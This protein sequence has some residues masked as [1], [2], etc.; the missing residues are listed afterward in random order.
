MENSN[1]EMLFAS[2]SEEMQE[3]VKACRTA[4]ELQTLVNA[5]PAEFGVFAK[6]QEDIVELSGDELEGVV[7]GR[8]GFA[9]LALAALMTFTAMGATMA[10][11]SGKNAMTSY[12]QK[13]DVQNTN[14]PDAEDMNRNDI[15]ED[16]AVN[17]IQTKY[18][19]AGDYSVSFSGSDLVFAK[20]AKNAAANVL[21]AIDPDF[22]LAMV[23]KDDIKVQYAVKT[24]AADESAEPVYEK[25]EL[26]VTAFSANGDKFSVSFTDPDAA[27]NK[28]GSYILYIE[29]LGAVAMVSVKFEDHTLSCDTER[30]S[31]TSES[32]TITLTTAEGSFSEEISA[33][34]IQ[35][36]GSF[37][38]MRVDSVRADGSQLHITLSGSPVLD[39]EDCST[40]MAGIIT[41]NENGFVNGDAPCS[42]Y[43][44][45]EAPGAFV[46]V[47]GMGWEN[48]QFVVPIRLSG[49]LAEDIS[50]EDVKLE[51]TIVREVKAAPDNI[52][53]AYLDM[54][55]PAGSSCREA[56]DFLSGKNMTVG[57]VETVCNI[58]HASFYPFFDYI[59][60]NGSE[61]R[62]TLKLRADGGTIADSMDESMISLSGDFKDGRIESFTV[63]DDTQ[64]TIILSLPSNGMTEE[65]YSLTGGIIFAEGALTDPWGE[66]APEAMY[67]RL[68][69]P[70]EM[71]RID[72]DT[73]F[74]Y[75]ISAM[76][77]IDKDAESVAK[78][79]KKTYDIA[80]KMVDIYGKLK[81]FDV[82]GTC[83]NVK[84]LLAMTGIITIEKEKSDTEIIKE[85]IAKMND[86]LKDINAKLDKTQKGIYDT[87]LTLFDRNVDGMASYAKGIQSQIDY[88]MQHLDDLGLTYP[89]NDAEEAELAQFKNELIH[90][91]IAKER[92]GGVKNAAYMGF[93]SDLDHMKDY[94]I[95]TVNQMKETTYDSS[96]LYY[97]DDVWTLYFNWNTEGHYAR[98]AYR[99][100]IEFQLKNA[101]NLMTVCYGLDTNPKLHPEI[102]EGYVAALKHLE[103]HPETLSAANALGNSMISTSQ[104][105]VYSYT[106]KQKVYWALG[107]CYMPYA[108]WKE[109]PSEITDDMINDYKSRL[110]GKTVK[111]DFEFA[112]FSASGEG[113]AMR[114][115]SDKGGGDFT[116]DVITRFLAGDFKNYKNNAFWAEVLFWDGTQKPI[117][118][119]DS[120][121]G[122]PGSRKVTILHLA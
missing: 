26:A 120:A 4:E 34:D 83:S 110:H 43:I 12:V 10:G 72:V 122:I 84:E 94:F 102:I 9:P 113:I 86:M 61:L 111:E 119:Y 15:T 63:D 46:D 92:E 95:N 99:T 33:E 62:L 89:G 31:S 76:S 117:K 51:G 100:N 11:A 115:G 18:N 39:L 5:N 114:T 93:S 38:D 28:T 79:G 96:P 3:K 21:D 16:V 54:D 14:A 58:A 27:E 71:G 59:E 20:D 29:K 22:T 69:A 109:Y 85:E 107:D 80:M 104:P 112:G 57:S 64:A 44:D 55:L 82:S 66:A 47:N 37:K 105:G 108:D 24:A 74:E 103:E 78:F 49:I 101:Y 30:I 56:A 41:V 48:G 88:A 25:R 118:T 53:Y 35:L 2:L 81:T 50:A 106:L 6:H 116:L 97:F 45:V 75:S 1:A 68:F 90:A 98:Q 73:A 42:T 13:N 52:I 121:Y 87:R 65:A 36:G 17:S 40:Y 32:N 77:Y 7:G 23:T 60:Q 70:E 91:I 67:A 8:G 19:R